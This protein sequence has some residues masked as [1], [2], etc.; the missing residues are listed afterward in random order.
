MTENLH[1][2]HET[3]TNLPLLISLRDRKQM[4]LKTTYFDI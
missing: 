4:I 3:D 1:D 2:H